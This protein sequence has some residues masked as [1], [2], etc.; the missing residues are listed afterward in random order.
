[1]AT[2]ARRLEVLNEV[3]RIATLDLELR[4]MLQRVTDTLRREF[5]WEFIAC[6]SI[7]WERGHFVCEA[8]S[9]ELPTEIHAGYS[10]PLGSGVVGEVAATGR[11]VYVEDA[12]TH[13]NW[14]DTLPGGMSELCVPV[15]HAGRILAVLN[16]ESTRLDAFRGQL[17]LLE[18]VAEQ[19]AG[20]IANARLY[21]ELRRRARLLEMVSEVSKAALEA[22]EL[23]LLL[24]RIVDY[25]FAHFALATAAILL[26]DEERGEFQQ[27]AHAG[28][29]LQRVPLGKKWRLADGIVGRSIRTGEPQLVPDVHADPDYVDVDASVGAEYAVPIRLRGRILGVLNLE[30]TG[31]EVFTPENVAVFNTFAD[32]M[33]GAI[34]MAAIN[35]E[36]E[37][38]NARLTRA[39][40][41]LSRISA[42][43]G[44]TGIANRR[45]FDRRLALEWR[46]AARA[47]RPLSLLLADIDCFKDYNDLHGHQQGDA[48][49]R[50]VAQGLASSLHRA[51]DMVARYGGEEF[52]VLLADT[53]ESH[54]ATT[55]EML[56]ARV[57]AMGIPHG[58]SGVSAV[59]TLSLGVATTRPRAGLHPLPLVE[60]AD[61]ALYLAKR[62]GRNRVCTEQ[63]P[64]A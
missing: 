44:L 24:Q 14:V 39:N 7:D 11:P 51:G 37:D 25:I 28:G 6:V 45:R 34:H 58:A 17:P 30:G 13:P 62:A 50:Q 59:V 64:S 20:A 36:L 47:Q 35:R 60:S 55:A 56:R 52:A 16:L 4:P 15:R 42:R 46:R 23:H 29:V 2:D 22:G 26:L 57:E 48:C 43:D 18:T 3:A 53:D 12:R 63:E 32:Q 38:A 54:A 10:R 1:M 27:T 5:G 40:R 49:L 41:R 19:V 31:P 8:L 33:A 9:T 21:D 61:R